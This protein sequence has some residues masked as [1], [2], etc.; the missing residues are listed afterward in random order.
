MFIAESYQ[1]RGGG[2]AERLPSVLAEKLTDQSSSVVGKADEP[3]IEGGV[4]K[5]GEQEA[6][7]HVEALCI[8]AIRPGHDVRRSKQGRI[9]DAGDGASAA[10]IINQRVAEHV[11]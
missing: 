10:P 8:R 7:V 4:P 3:S 2:R 1:A 6:V 11:L 5:C 9:G